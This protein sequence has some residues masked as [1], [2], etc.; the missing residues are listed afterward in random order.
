M[1]P[2][3]DRSASRL[4]AIQHGAL[5]EIP[6]VQLSPSANLPQW[7]S[8]YHV[9]EATKLL[10]EQMQSGNSLR[11]A[12]GKSKYRFKSTAKKETL[13]EAVKE[14]FS[15]SERCKVVEQLL[16]D[17]SDVGLV[18]AVLMYEGKNLFGD[19]PGL[20]SPTDS[21]A[22][23]LA[24]KLCALSAKSGRIPGIENW[25][26]IA[27]KNENVQ[28]VQLLGTRGVGQHAFDRGLGVALGTMAISNPM[29]FPTVEELIRYGADANNH[30]ELYMKAVDDGRVDIV[31]ACMRGRR[32]LKQ[33]YLNNALLLAEKN[34]AYNVVAMLL[35]YGADPND[36]DAQAFLS[37]VRAGDL[38]M[39]SLLVAGAQGSVKVRV[40]YLDFAVTIGCEGRDRRFVYNLLNILLCGGASSGSK[41]V[42][43][44]LVTALRAG[45][46]NLVKLL[47]SFGASTDH[48]NA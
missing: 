45:D 9:G 38:R 13:S 18:E 19:V 15:V 23:K 42:E 5:L 39:I 27:V 30:P 1:I 20:G 17:N 34:A 32:K 12:S 16:K 25:A 31:E 3:R 29:A 24:R 22:S 14:D 47:N 6:R 10:M 8:A 41:S 46:S 43:E 35:A 4:L 37:S 28:H 36:Q 40:E 7:S 44:Q 33:V 26:T 21:S 48:G 11:G 2:F